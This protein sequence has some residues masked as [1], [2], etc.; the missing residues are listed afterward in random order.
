MFIEK[1]SSVSVESEQ[2]VGNIK[3]LAYHTISYGL[4]T[5]A[6]CNVEL[7]E[8][9]IVE[10]QAIN[11]TSIS[12]L[13][14]YIGTMSYNSNGGFSSNFKDGVNSWEHLKVFEEFI[15]SIKNNL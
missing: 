12:N 8:E 4:V 15:T 10:T 13:N 7:V 6:N 11:P 14:K 3:Y 5:S 9:P 2:T 1:K